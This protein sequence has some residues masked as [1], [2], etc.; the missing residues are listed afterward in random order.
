MEREVETVE[1]LIR[2]AGEWTVAFPR[3]A[4]DQPERER[5]DPGTAGERA[6]LLGAADLRETLGA[7]ISQPHVLNS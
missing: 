7:H 1:W 3:G 5:R 4:G 2:G 6:R